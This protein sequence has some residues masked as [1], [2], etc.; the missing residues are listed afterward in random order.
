MH[1]RQP[2]QLA[3]SVTPASPLALD[4]AWPLPARQ[5]TAAHVATAHLR[6]QAWLEAPE[7]ADLVGDARVDFADWVRLHECPAPDQLRLQQVCT[8]WVL[9][10]LDWPETV[11]LQLAQAAEAN[12]EAGVAATLRYM[13]DSQLQLWQV[14][15]DAPDGR[16]LVALE[17]PGG[18]EAYA[19]APSLTGDL[20]MM[21][22][23][24]GRLLPLGDGELAFSAGVLPYAAA[25]EVGANSEASLT[26]MGFTEAQRSSLLMT[27]AMV[28]AGFWAVEQASVR[29]RLALL[30]AA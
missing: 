30:P 7:N 2:L 12:G 22:W 28:Q 1:H 14:F 25:P 16:Y 27:Q 8:E 5:I 13:H 11:A 10:D 24:A 29:E 18:R 6:L 19:R 3:R 26:L 17:G 4:T 15:E 20:P 21:I 23:L 9:F